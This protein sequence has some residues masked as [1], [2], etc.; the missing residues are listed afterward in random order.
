MVVCAGQDA[1]RYRLSFPPAL[2]VSPQPCTIRSFIELACCHVHDG[3]SGIFFAG[4]EIEAVEFEEK[5]SYDKAGA[6]V[7]IY[8]RMVANDTG[9]VQG[10]QLNNAGRAGIGMVLAGPGQSGLQKP[11]VSHSRSATVER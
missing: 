2:H 8:K 5:N 6:F 9:C 10:S 11:L 7:A 4:V 1:D 3:L